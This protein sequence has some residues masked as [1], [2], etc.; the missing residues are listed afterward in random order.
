MTPAS[1]ERATTC[2]HVVPGSRSDFPTDVH[3]YQKAPSVEML[4]LWVS[5]IPGH[6]R[7]D[8]GIG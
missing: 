1:H 6:Q 4:N 3:W 7:D 8:I 5:S 2:L